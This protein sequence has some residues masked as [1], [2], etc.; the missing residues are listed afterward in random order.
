MPVTAR[1]MRSGRPAKK[2]MKASGGPKMHMFKMNGAML[3]GK[4][5]N[6]IMLPSHCC[7]GHNSFT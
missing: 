1:P 2:K 5:R 6:F 3:V 4:A 7:S